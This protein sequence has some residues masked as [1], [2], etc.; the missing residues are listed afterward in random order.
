ME[1]NVLNFSIFQE[2][3]KSANEYQIDTESLK[4]HQK[5]FARTVLIGKKLKFYLCLHSKPANDDQN[6]QTCAS[7]DDR[8]HVPPNTYALLLRQLTRIW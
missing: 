2:I 1:S 8:I 3:G 5:Y 7:N 4:K 6:H